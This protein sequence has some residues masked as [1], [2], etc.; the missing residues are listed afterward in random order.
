LLGIDQKSNRQMGN[1]VSCPSIHVRLV[2][3]VE[4]PPVDEP[5][6]I[7]GNN[8]SCPQTIISSRLW[9]R[10]DPGSGFQDNESYS[11]I[12]TEKFREVSGPIKFSIVTDEGE[13][14]DITV[15]K[16][17]VGGH[18]NV[19]GNEE[20]LRLGFQLMPRGNDVTIQFFCFNRIRSY[21][22]RK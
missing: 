18:R 19:I 4:A 15:R 10:L 21:R 2:Y 7:C 1:K 6:E 11:F 16:V 17:L 8:E 9:E 13:I 12:P 5:F 22:T 3:D 14:R 20:K